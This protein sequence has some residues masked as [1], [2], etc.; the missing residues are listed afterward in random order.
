[1]ATWFGPC[2]A[3]LPDVIDVYKQYHAQG[4]EIVGISLDRS[5]R[6][7]ERFLKENPDMDWPQVYDGKYWD[8]EVGVLYGVDSIP[9]ALLLDGAGTIRYRDLRGDELGKAVAQLLAEASK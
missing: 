4:L 7:M 1:M 6:D 3:D 5:E 2:I 8:A 9:Y